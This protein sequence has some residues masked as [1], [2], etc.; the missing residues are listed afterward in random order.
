[1]TEF[2]TSCGYADYAERF[3][4]LG[5]DSWQS[6]ELMDRDDLLACGVKLGHVKVNY[7]SLLQ[8][9]QTLQACVLHSSPR[10]LRIASQFRVFSAYSL[11]HI[12]CID[13]VCLFCAAPLATLH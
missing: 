8:Q 4:E 12:I 11:L 7:H 1:M 9:Y 2:L 3:V 5:F 10:T 13:E 6:V